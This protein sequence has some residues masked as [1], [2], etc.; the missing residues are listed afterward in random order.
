MPDH[1]ISSCSNIVGD[2]AM[3][4]DQVVNLKTGAPPYRCSLL[5]Y[6]AETLSL[7]LTYKDIANKTA[8][9]RSLS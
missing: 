6:F 4:H 1:P 5:C 3:N 2:H 8:S 9:P 7:G